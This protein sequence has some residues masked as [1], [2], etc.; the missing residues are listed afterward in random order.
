MKS[1]EGKLAVVLLGATSIV[2]VIGIVICFL[3]V[4][5]YNTYIKYTDQDK[6]IEVQAQ[7]FNSTTFYTS[8][9]N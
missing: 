1:E 3:A 7:N 8:L 2:L 4:L 5:G 6:K 9:D